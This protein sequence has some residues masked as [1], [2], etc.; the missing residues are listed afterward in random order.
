MSSATRRAASGSTAPSP[1]TL[2]AQAA[3]RAAALFR[4]PVGDRSGSNRGGPAARLSDRRS[5]RCLAP[6]RIGSSQAGARPRAGRRW[7]GRWIG[8]GRAGVGRPEPGGPLLAGCPP[9][10]RRPVA[11]GRPVGTAGRRG[12]AGGRCAAG[13]AGQF[14]PGRPSRR[15]ATP[16]PA[17]RPWAPRRRDGGTGDTDPLG[18]EL[19]VEALLA[20]PEVEVDEDQDG[21]H[22][23]RGDHRRHRCRR[24]S[25]G[26]SPTASR[27]PARRSGTR[28]GSRGRAR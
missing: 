23:R 17:Q 1:T 19:E 8:G 18:Q 21:G 27:S 25:R 22:E 7:G 26:R 6:G 28:A 2:T 15:A 14:P 20:D 11:A 5:G 16:E 9:V 3:R 13:R 4:G 24:R 12:A 10:R